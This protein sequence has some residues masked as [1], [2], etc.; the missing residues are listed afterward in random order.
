MRKKVK[1]L[2]KKSNLE[3][4]KR[5]FWG[6]MFKIKWKKTEIWRLSQN[7]EEKNNRILRKKSHKFDK[8]P[9]ILMKTRESFLI[10]KDAEKSHIWGLTKKLKYCEGYCKKKKLSYW[11]AKNSTMKKVSFCRND[12]KI[13]VFL[14]FFYPSLHRLSFL[15]LFCQT[16]IFIKVIFPCFCL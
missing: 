9:K 8:E 14:F 12:A 15:L 2:R 5:K 6:K 1:N 11:K 16:E 4:T 7:F 13:I 10:K 3:E